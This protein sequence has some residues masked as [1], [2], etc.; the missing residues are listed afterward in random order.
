MTS[1]D[2]GLEVIQAARRHLQLSDDE[3]FIGRVT[4]LNESVE[5]HLENDAHRGK[6]DAVVVSEV[7]EHVIDKPAF[8]ETC[9]ATVKVNGDFDD[10]V[11]PALIIVIW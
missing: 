8:L 5:D 11:Y 3:Q 4:Y 9:V 2:P 7:I 1:I 10:F 6:Y